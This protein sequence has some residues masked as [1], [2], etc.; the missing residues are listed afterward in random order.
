MCVCLLA[1]SFLSKAKKRLTWP[2]E[3]LAN[4]WKVWP[5]N[6]MFVMLPVKNVR[7]RKD[8]D[9]LFF[10]MFCKLKFSQI[11]GGF[12]L[13][14]SCSEIRFSLKMLAKKFL[15]NFCFSPTKFFGEIQFFS[16]KVLT[17]KVSLKKKRFLQTY[18]WHFAV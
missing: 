11:Y 15:P 10:K 5:K 12:C 8:C 14:K 17:H 18:A 13:V 1:T 16:Y 4:T 6:L 9:R 7:K 3:N 2:V